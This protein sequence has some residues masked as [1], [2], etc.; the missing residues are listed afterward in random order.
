MKKI[1]HE[2]RRLIIRRLGYFGLPVIIM[3][4][5]FAML[6]IAPFGKGSLL[7]YDMGEQYVDFF[8]FY[9]DTLLHHP[10]QLLY[11]FTNGIGG[12]TLGLWAYYLLSPFNLILLFFS[13]QTLPMAILVMTLLKYGCAGLAFGICLEKM[14]W[15]DQK[16]I[17]LGSVC[18]AL[19]GWMLANQ[20]NIMWLDVLVFLPFVLNGIEKIFSEDRSFYY[21][22]FLALTLFINFYMGYMVCIFVVLYFIW[23][24]IRKWQGWKNLWKKTARWGISSLLAAGSVAFLLLPTYFDITKSKGVY[25]QQ[26]IR[27]VFE[28]QPW[29]MLSKF[30]IG[31][32]NDSQIQGGLPN[33]FVCSLIIL[34][35]V[36]YFMAKRIPWRE[37]FAS[38]GICLLMFFAMCW[39]PL[40]LIWHAFQ[41]PVFYPYRFS[42]LVST[43]MI[44]LA[45]R[46]FTKIG[47][48]HLYQLGIALLI[49][50]I[51]WIVVFVGRKHFNFLTL[52]NLI[53]TVV[54]LLCIFG[55]LVWMLMGWDR[56]FKHLHL[57]TLAT[58]LMFLLV[59][60]ECSMNAYQTVKN[61]G[62]ADIRTYTSFVG[63]LDRDIQWIQ[64]HPSESGFY[65]VGKTFQRSEN[66][67]LNAGYHGVSGFTSTQ[68]AAVTSFMNSMGQ[69]NFLGKEVY[70]NGTLL[71]DSIL[72]IRFYMAP[73]DQYDHLSNGNN[74]IP[75][76]SY[77]P[78]ISFY[79]PVKKSKGVT[80]Y[81][82]PLALSIGFA[83]NRHVL[84]SKNDFP[85]DHMTVDNQEY[86]LNRIAGTHRHFF[87]PV[88]YQIKLS[89]CM[90]DGGSTGNLVTL[91]ANE[92]ASMSL[93]MKNI[94]IDP[95][96]LQMAPQS[97]WD[98]SITVN[99]NG[100]PGIGN[101]TQP[102]LFNVA[103][104]NQGADL[105][106]NINPNK[107]KTLNLNDL[108]VYKFNVDR[109]EKTIY[110]VM[111]NQLQLT[112]NGR[113]QIRG[114]IE[115]PHGKD[116][117]MTTIPYNKGWH[118]KVDGQRV[119]PRKAFG[120]FIAV[121]M[122]AG[123][124]HVTLSFWPPLLT[125][126]I[127]ITLLTWVI[128]VLCWR[129]ESRKQ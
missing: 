115:I 16:W 11:S 14:Q 24:A 76:N 79:G 112:H 39:Q 21:T 3:L 54:F 35:L 111:A 55:V 8:A 102:V 60:A 33:L 70:S 72:G 101:A 61:L 107:G 34:G 38:F 68:N 45:L 110:Q 86:L 122:T 96:Y 74:M 46:G 93:I 22:L 64:A 20:F 127:I 36:L 26:N 103:G 29:K 50:L 108:A 94:S 31:S 73:S 47:Q 85:S 119:T 65:R 62:G 71:T 123:V 129:Y 17:S 59:I 77:R 19:M 78:D 99:G 37:K 121:P 6:H 41:Y 90:L 28:Y 7:T 106:V 117:M 92:P 66:D 4:S 100:L 48:P 89:N 125:L 58:G 69:P 118:V 40:D 53:A 52:P 81:H 5:V 83:A 126:G 1:S 10:S 12:E 105:T 95:Y 63:N 82:N 114:D 25:T 87:E 13:K 27:P 49:P 30:M 51:C 67:A 42:Y 104:N 109:F 15:A 18:Y 32:L 128:L 88:H 23:T 9:R 116:V 56:C 84:S 57:Q 91:D 98:S 113:L 80:I 2:K 75:N 120:T 44:L 97:V 124:H 43:W